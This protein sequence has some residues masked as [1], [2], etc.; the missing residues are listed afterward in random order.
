VEIAAEDRPDPLSF[1]VIDR[2]LS[3]LGVIAEWGHASDPEP[4]ALIL[5]SLGKRRRQDG[6]YSA[7]F[8]EMKRSIPISL[9]ISVGIGIAKPK[10]VTM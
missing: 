10:R 3:T 4:L 6:V 5:R 1:S 8:V 7:Y 9:A 2:N